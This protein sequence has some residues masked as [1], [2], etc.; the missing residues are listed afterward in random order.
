MRAGCKPLRQHQGI[1]M[2]LLQPRGHVRQGQQACK[3]PVLATSAQPASPVLYAHQHL[4]WVRESK[5]SITSPLSD[6]QSGLHNQ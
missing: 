6:C 5:L 1:V 3:A 2:V 4:G